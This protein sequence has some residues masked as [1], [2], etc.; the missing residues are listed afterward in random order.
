[1]DV[2]EVVESWGGCGG[3]SPLSGG[4]EPEWGA[5]FGDAAGDAD[6]PAV[7]VE[8]SVVE[9]AQHHAVVGVGGAAVR[10]VDDVVR[11]SSAPKA[12]IETRTSRRGRRIRG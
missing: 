6:V 9:P 10:I 11:L 1:M 3:G 7:P 4:V 8:E 5:D 2:D 12:C